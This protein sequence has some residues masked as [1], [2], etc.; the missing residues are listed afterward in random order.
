[1]ERERSCTEAAEVRVEELERVL[2]KV[3]R[4][5]FPVPAPG[6]SLP[7]TPARGPADILTQ[8]MIQAFI[9]SCPSAGA[10]FLSGQFVF[11]SA[12]LALAH[13]LTVSP[14]PP[15]SF[16]FSPYLSFLSS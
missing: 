16:S 2:E 13:S 14:L 5:E 8:G 3:N 15:L 9:I 11:P 1:M 6:P 10:L 12:T 4:G 7:L